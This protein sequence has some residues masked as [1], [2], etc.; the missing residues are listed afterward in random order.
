YSL[1]RKDALN[2]GRNNRKRLLR[3]LQVIKARK[4]KN[5]LR[6][7]NKRLYDYLLIE[8]NYSSRQA[9]YDSINAKVDEMFDD[10]WVKEVKSIARKYKNVDLMNNN[11]FKALGY[12]DIL[13]ALENN[14]EVN[15]SLIK[16]KIRHFAKRQITWINNKYPK[17]LLFAQDNEEEIFKNIKKW[18]NK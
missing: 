4:S 2:I 6:A 17:H 12:R 7:K 8:C 16:Q 5:A 3:A 18:I 11:A 15:I 9:L 14:E 1:S 10:G 13:L